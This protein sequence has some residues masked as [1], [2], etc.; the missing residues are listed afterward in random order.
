MNNFAKAALDA[1][2]E[3]L[4]QVHVYVLRFHVAEK[5]DTLM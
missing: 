2:N 3:N 4:N 1:I 5:I